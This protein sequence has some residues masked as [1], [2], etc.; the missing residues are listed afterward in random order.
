MIKKNKNQIKSY[1]IKILNTF[2]I[3]SNLKK[4]RKIT[5]YNIDILNNITYF[6]Y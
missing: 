1:F 4:K 3:Q 5:I 6:Q 2:L